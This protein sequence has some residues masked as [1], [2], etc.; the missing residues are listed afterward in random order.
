MAI[1]VGKPDRRQYNHGRNG[2]AGAENVTVAAADADTDADD[3]AGTHNVDPDCKT[4]ANLVLESIVDNPAEKNNPPE[5]VDGSQA[6]DAIALHKEHVRKS[7]S[8]LHSSNIQLA[9]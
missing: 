8:N 1:R 6:D 9:N 5:I 7:H 3:H 2:V 4:D